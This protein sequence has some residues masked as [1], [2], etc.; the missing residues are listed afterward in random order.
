MIIETVSQVFTMTYYSENKN[1]TTPFVILNKTDILNVLK[2]A[3]YGKINDEIFRINL[4]LKNNESLSIKCFDYELTKFILC[5]IDNNKD[6]NFDA[7]NQQFS[8]LLV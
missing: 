6:I 5:S 4:D 2:I 1:I 8:E 7:V 3:T